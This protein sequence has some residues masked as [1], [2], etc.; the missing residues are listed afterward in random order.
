MF[1][2]FAM[3]IA[4]LLG[5]PSSLHG[6]MG[7]TGTLEGVV[8]D[9]ATGTPLMGANV[10]IVGTPYGAAADASG[11]FIV[12]NI[13]PGLYTVRV[14]MLGYQTAL[15]QR[16]EI[17]P[18]YKTRLNVDLEQTSIEM[19]QVI[20]Q[21]ER[22]PIE[23]EITG[24]TYRFSSEDLKALPVTTFKDVVGFKAGTTMEGN[25]RGGKT[26]EV[27]Y[28]I[29][30]IPVQDLI[31]GGL[32]SDLP[33]S[34]IVE[35]SIQT[36]GFDAEFGNALSGV[37][38][39]ITRSGSNEYDAAFRIDRD[40]LFG[41]TQNNKEQELELSAGG[42]VLYDKMFYFVSANYYSSGTRWWQDMDKFF[43]PPTDKSLNLFTKLDY[44]FTS[45]V[46]L[47]TQ[48]LLSD[49]EWRD[50]EF[51]WRFNL[52]G[53]P[54]RDRKTTRIAAILSHTF[55]ESS[56]YTIRLS[57]QSISSLIG[58]SK[59]AID[60]TDIYQYDFYLQYIIDGSRS[61]FSESAQNTT[62]IKA[63][64]T[65][66]IA[67][68]HVLKAGAEFNLYDVSADV[69]KYE[70]RKTF[71]GKP[72]LTEP[73][74]N[75]STA[76][77]YRPRSGS[78]YIQDKIEPEA[79]MIFSIG[80]RYD[81]L[82]P[83]ASRPAIEQIPS[84]NPND[85]IKFRPV[86]FVKAKLKQQ[87]S[88]R[89]GFAMP[90]AEDMFLFINYGHYFQF[91][92]FDYLYSGLDV[93][94]LQ[95]GASAVVGNPDLEPERTQAWEISLRRVLN[96]EFVASVTYFQKRTTNQID[97]KTFVAIDSKAAGDFGFTEYV[98]NPSAEASGFEFVLTRQGGV[99][100]NGDVSYTF[101]KAEGLS[102]RASQGLDY[103]QWGFQ[104]V[105]SLFPLSWDQRHSVKVNL[106]F[107]LP[108][109]I[110]ARLFWNFYTARPYT[111]YPSRDGFTPL[112]PTRL[113]VP[114][115]ARMQNFNNID[116]RV[117]RAFDLG[118]MRSSSLIAYVDVRNLLHERNVKWIDSSG[119]IGGELGDPSAYFIG[120]RTKVGIRMEVGF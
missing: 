99:F 110:D 21:A 60:P 85:T 114:N 112:D 4:G 59:E 43:G 26:T 31:S 35:M 15:V 37:V 106:A 23:K 24:T 71:F 108:F 9:K 75:F 120:R 55:A 54:I 102:D 116:I 5:F 103:L 38:N 80:L 47:S 111:Y 83:T 117:Q 20:I 48:L 19:D 6:F 96:K 89:I 8:K 66:Q 104:P 30:G 40:N 97:T 84:T 109:D 63:D 92:L 69:L 61:M 50:Y 18:D 29:D 87:F 16:V 1:I 73:Q 12:Y 62:T 56:F 45:D 2:S 105:T 7:T 34:S 10:I 22:P 42:P 90:L 93:V 33:T 58:E 95:R 25:V 82:D 77:N 101:M 107:Q 11:K 64:I 100:L 49:K 79:G 28:L 52:D 57:H 94:T 67:G 113:F 115:N 17:R 88:P 41:G 44:Q 51:S 78:I 3:L 39:V 118:L 46:R 76:Y 70:P 53:L 81:F 27:S 86:G 119:R 91:P 65:S 74:L 72:I 98:N 32:S 13:P 68:Y 36:G 14:Q